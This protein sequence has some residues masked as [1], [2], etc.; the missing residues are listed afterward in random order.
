MDDEEKKLQLQKAHA[1]VLGLLEESGLN[2]AEGVAILEGAKFELMLRNLDAKA[3]MT[4]IKHK[5][6]KQLPGGD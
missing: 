6:E 2:N 1:G 5:I 4:A 3:F